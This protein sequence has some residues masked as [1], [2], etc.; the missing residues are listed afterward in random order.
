[1]DLPTLGTSK[2]IL[3]APLNWGLG[4]AMRMIPVINFYK[5]KHRVILVGEKEILALWKQYYPNLEKVEINSG[6]QVN[7]DIHFF[8]LFRLFSFLRKL[9]TLERHDLNKAIQLQK[10][11][12]A[13]IIISDNRYGFYT[14][15]TKNILVTHQLAP[16]L[17]ARYKIF[18]SL[19]RKN[20]LKKIQAFDECWVPDEEYEMGL[21]GKLSHLSVMPKNVKFI[22]FLSR[23]ENTDTQ[24]NNSQYFD[25]VVILS[26]PEP[27]RSL[28]EQ[29][30]VR[31]LKNKP[32]SVAVFQG[33]QFQSVVREMENITFFSNVDDISFFQLVKW[34]KLVVARAGYSTIMDLNILQKKAILI[35]SPQQ[36]EQEY[37]AEHLKN[38]TLFTTISEQ[39]LQSLDIETLF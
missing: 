30:I 27:Q 34:A 7:F 3:I 19:V 39:Q 1:M 26:G 29:R 15:K 25:I 14:S 17:P 6:F 9:Q 13:D 23:F 4:H 8:S 12:N 36:T 2:T 16:I 35:P 20:I 10:E 33:K 31:W 18:Q 32:F 5:S 37:L 24:A 21:S 28:F 38:N 11:F 22:G